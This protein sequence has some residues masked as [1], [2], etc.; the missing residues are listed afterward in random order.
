[1]PPSHV[2]RQ[3]FAGYDDQ[4]PRE[5][6]PPY[7]TQPMYDQYDNP[8]SYVPELAAHIPSPPPSSTSY[9]YR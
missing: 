7:R 6:R 1:M 3:Q 2:Q 5:R 8:H 9:H 4:Q